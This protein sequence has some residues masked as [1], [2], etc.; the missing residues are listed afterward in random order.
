MWLCL[1][2][3]SGSASAAHRIQP[4]NGILC[5]KARV[6]CKQ[7]IDAANVLYRPPLFLRSNKTR[8]I[9][10]ISAGELKRLTLDASKMLRWMAKH[11]KTGKAWRLPEIES[12]V[13]DSR[14]SCIGRESA[15]FIDN[16]QHTHVLVH[17]NTWLLSSPTYTLTHRIDAEKKKW[18]ALLYTARHTAQLETV[19]HGRAEHSAHTTH[20]SS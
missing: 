20:R 16:A 1:C 17:A 19:R 4:M 14:T 2:W 18:K 3:H 13:R 5:K 15:A 12:S 8:Q 11:A 9:Q 7:R 6:E 10:H